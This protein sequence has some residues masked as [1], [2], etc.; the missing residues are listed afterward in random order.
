MRARLALLC[1]PILALGCSDDD[2]G[3]VLEAQTGQRP[4]VT[5]VVLTDAGPT[6]GE[7][8]VDCVPSGAGEA[9]DGADDDCDGR[10]DEDAL[11]V[12]DACGSAVGACE[13]GTFAC[14][15]GA[16]VCRGGVDPRPETCAALD[17]DC[18]G[19]VGEGR[20]EIGGCLDDG[21][22][23]ETSDRCRS[24][25]CLADLDDEYCSRPCEDDDDCDGLRCAETPSTFGTGSLRCLR[26]RT[27]CEG[28]GDCE[29]PQVCQRV[30]RA[31]QDDQECRRPGPDALPGG[32]DCDRNDLCASRSCGFEPPH[33]ADACVGED[34]CNDDTTCVA[35]SSMDGATQGRCVRTC[36]A[37]DAACAMGTACVYSRPVERDAAEV[38]YRAWCRAYPPGARGLGELCTEHDE[39][40]SLWCVDDQCTKGC[41]ADLDCTGG[42]LCGEERRFTIGE[43]VTGIIRLCEPP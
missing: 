5:V 3:K 29:R 35:F 43:G 30:P 27:T 38:P 8:P 18:D 7:P 42:T 24:G 36:G 40:Q 41:A 4:P 33:C 31:A 12:G 9:C 37:R 17:L 1:V 23:C 28:N 13:Q 34:D 20:P 15:N 22:D 14:M 11:G 26:V 25:E 6:D 39:C 16:L 32:A 10:I 2:A 19:T 21:A